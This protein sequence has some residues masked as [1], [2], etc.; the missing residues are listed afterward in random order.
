MVTHRKVALE[1]GELRIVARDDDS[2]GQAVQWAGVRAARAE[3]LGA[4]LE[5][6]A[7]RAWCK[8]E[9]L[10]GR[11]AWRHGLRTVLLRSPL[12][13]LREFQNLQWLR[14]RCFEAPEPLAA[15]VLW[16]GGLPRWQFLITREVEDARELR[17]LLEADA[18]EVAAALD[19]LAREVAR[20]HALRFIHRD[21]FPRN[22]LVRSTPAP[23][24]IVLLDA[25]RGGARAQLRGV[26]YDL[27]CL[28][29]QLARWRSTAQLSE[30]L[31]LYIEQR[32][33]QGQPV[34]AAKLERAIARERAALARRYARR[35]RSDELASLVE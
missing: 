17:E 10:P 30:W 4:A 2:A 24:R 7:T 12:P 6:G 31:E 9:P 33:V 19:E 34:D 5:L 27:A 32:N 13:R 26:A 25:W 18:P 21:L 14:A 11:A 28:F 22:I 1:A 15:G 23:R 35:G 8:A 20:M 3:I 16:R 29:L